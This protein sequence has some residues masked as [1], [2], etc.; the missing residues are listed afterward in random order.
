MGVK[1]QEFQGNMKARGQ[2]RWDCQRKVVLGIAEA[3]CVT[4]NKEALQ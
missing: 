4:K 1:G 3:I 2:M